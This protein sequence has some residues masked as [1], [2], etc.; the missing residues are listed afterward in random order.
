MTARTFGRRGVSD[1]GISARRAVLLGLA[2]APAEAR[3]A[4]DSTAR[5]AA[6]VAEERARAEPPAAETLAYQVTPAA[7]S[8]A[9][10]G[11]P[12]S[13]AIAYALWL[14]LGLAGA[15]RFYLGRYVSGALQATL[16]LGSWGLLAA[17][18]YPAFAGM[19]LALAWMSADAYFVRRM[20]ARPPR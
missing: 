5:R 13:L 4:D 6:F 10:W 11:K 1:G 8:A 18:Y 19:A 7:V 20:H 16:G 12:K 15:H 9:V 14:V 17:E 3:E 2:A